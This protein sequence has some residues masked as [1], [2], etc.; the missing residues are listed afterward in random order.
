MAVDELRHLLSLREIGLGHQVL[1]PMG[2]VARLKD[3][4]E[5]VD[6]RHQRVGG[7]A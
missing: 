5:A 2:R 3:L 4:H 1:H 7:F 6:G